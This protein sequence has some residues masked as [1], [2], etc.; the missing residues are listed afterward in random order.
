[1]SLRS[2][3]CA[4]AVAEGTPA[5]KKIEQVCFFA[6]LIV[7]WLSPKVLPLGKIQT[8]LFFRSLNRTFARK[9]VKM[10]RKM[11]LLIV[12]MMLVLWGV[13]GCFQ[14]MIWTPIVAIMATEYQDSIRPKAMFAISMT[15]IVGYLVGQALGWGFMDSIFLGGML[16]MSSTT[17]IIKAFDD[18]G[19][20]NKKFTQLVFGALVVEDMVAILIL[21]LLPA[22]S[23]SV[24]FMIIKIP[25]QSAK[26]ENFI[27]KFK[28]L[29]I[30]MK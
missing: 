18:M 8:S 28:R 7:L 17:I 23:A 27:E 22:K 24:T 25:N 19:V 10:K 4:L 15:L 12:G 9:F 13:N 21:V 5:R 29:F 11:L 14:S 16:S 6:R 26:I 30:S 2:L 3:N 1:M 20:K